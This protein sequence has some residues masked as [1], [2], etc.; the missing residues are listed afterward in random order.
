MKEL[1]YLFWVFCRIGVCTFGGGYAMLPII[2]RELVESRG[3][4]TD[5]EITD[6]Y[7]IGQM[8]PGVIAVNVATFVGMKRKGV[9]GAICTTLGVITPSVIIIIAIAAVLM[10]FMDNPYVIH[11]F[12]GIRVAVLGL[13]LKTIV[14]LIKKGVKD[15]FTFL[16]FLATVSTIFMPVSPAIVVFAAAILGILFKRWVVREK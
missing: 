1:L 2:Q 9:P 6:Y 5:E 10:K 4:L 11:A 16:I 12:A 13:M 7:A 15:W 3:W 8:T 14:T